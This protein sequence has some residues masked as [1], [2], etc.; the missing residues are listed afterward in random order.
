MHRHSQGLSLV[1]PATHQ[2]KTNSFSFH[3]VNGPRF[4]AWAINLIQ[5]VGELMKSSVAL[6]I[7][8]GMKILRDNLG[9]VD[10]GKQK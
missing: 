2:D 8:D 9:M 6:V 5:R 1:L 3:I 7:T 4:L 10:D